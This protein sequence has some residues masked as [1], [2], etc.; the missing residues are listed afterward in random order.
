MARLLKISKLIYYIIKEIEGEL[1]LKMKIIYKKF[2][3]PTCGQER[4]LKVNGICSDCRDKLILD[5]IAQNR[6]I[7]HYSN[8]E[9]VI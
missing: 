5:K 4:L 8:I 7:T 3:C 9:T 2:L 6:K 1:L